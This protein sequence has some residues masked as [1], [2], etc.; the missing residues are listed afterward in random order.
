[1]LP[2]NK[3]IASVYQHRVYTLFLMGS[4]LVVLL[5]SACERPDSEDENGGG[6]IEASIGELQSRLDDGQI[7]SVDL[8][9]FYL[10]RIEAFDKNGPSLNSIAYINPN[11]REQAEILDQERLEN[12]PRGPLHGIPILVK[13]NYETR[14]MPTTAGSKSLAG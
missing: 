9:D 6:L 1:M 12:G 4:M 10:A 2:S 14:G 7:M 13:D 3:K 5:V 8:V 11:A